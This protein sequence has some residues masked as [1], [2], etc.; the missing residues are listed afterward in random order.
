V[1]VQSIA[2]TL[3]V[4]VTSTAVAITP[5]EGNLLITGVTV[6]SASLSPTV[7][8][9]EGNSWTLVDIVTGTGIRIRAAWAIANSSAATTITWTLGGTSNAECAVTERDEFDPANPLQVQA[10][11]SGTGTAISSGNFTTEVDDSAIW[12]YTA[13]N[14]I[15][16]I[17]P[18]TGFTARA[19]TTFSGADIAQVS[20]DETNT[21][22]T[23]VATATA[24]SSVGWVI[25]VLVINPPSAGGTTF[26]KDLSETITTSDATSR[27]I[28]A[29]LEET[30]G[31]DATLLKQARRTMAES[32]SL[33]DALSRLAGKLH[34]ETVTASDVFAA[35]LVYLLVL[36]ETVDA[37]DGL[38]KRTARLLAEQVS[39]DDAVAKL[40][41]AL[42]AETVSIAASVQKAVLKA[43][44][45]EGVSAAD[46]LATIRVFVLLLQETVSLAD[47]RSN[48][49][50]KALA[51]TVSTS[52]GIQKLV[53]LVRLEA[54]SIVDTVRKLVV[55][56]Y[57]ETVSV[58]DALSVAQVAVL[59]LVEAI[60]VGD[61][62]RKRIG[63]ALTAG[64]TVTAG[65]LRLVG[66]VLAA[67]VTLT[68]G[69][70]KAVARFFTETLSAAAALTTGSGF[71]AFSQASI[72]VRHTRGA[73]LS[74]AHSYGAAVTPRGTLGASLQVR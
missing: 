27:A 15:V 70:G 2:S 57:S 74:T 59:V 5:T 63:K 60:G 34:A 35:Q 42:R 58:E 39:A 11:A 23:N 12:A 18:G 13:V 64:V 3:G 72:D 67:P 10:G 49:A 19:S 37:S 9:S 38:T 7:A 22:G 69:V 65:V 28:A 21:A 52:S 53:A 32:L 1:H 71:E 46:A 41:A 6:G 45:A 55:A 16:D 29:G 25:K 50:R 56:T 33:A 43:A 73:T 40:V 24:A 51:E 47:A 36:S 61:T 68:A 31:V 30:V 14:N 62:A 26:E 66:K 17:N 48:S 44:F 4:S 8:D 20:E 54:V